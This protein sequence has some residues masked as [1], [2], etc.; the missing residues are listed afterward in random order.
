MVVACEIS[1]KEAQAH[2]G[3]SLLNIHHVDDCNLITVHTVPVTVNISAVCYRT[4]IP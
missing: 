3:T 2:T 4:N 1:V